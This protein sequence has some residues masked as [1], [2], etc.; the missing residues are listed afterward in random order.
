MLS[1]WF[2][3]TVELGIDSKYN[4]IEKY[5]YTGPNNSGYIT[6]SIHMIKL[7]LNSKKARRSPL[8][9]LVI[10]KQINFVTQSNHSQT[11]M[12][13]IYFISLYVYGLS[14]RNQYRNLYKAAVITF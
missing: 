8:I 10:H 6:Q 7:Y 14:P 13:E 2:I 1:N 11:C 12:K 5:D 3:I 9:S 4:Y